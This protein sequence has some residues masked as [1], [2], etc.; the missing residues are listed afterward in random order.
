MKRKLPVF[1]VIMTVLAF[2]CFVL[3]YFFVAYCFIIPQY[4]KGLLFAIPFA[5][6][7]I[8]TICAYFGKVRKEAAAGITAVLSFVFI[9]SAFVLL[10]F[11]SFTE[12]TRAVED[13]AYYERA[14]TR[15]SV[16]NCTDG[17]ELLLPQNIPDN[18]EDV[19]FYYT[20]QVLQG[21]EIFFI[22]FKT[23]DRALDAYENELTQYA[24]WS[25][26]YEQAISADMNILYP[27]TLRGQFDY[28][29]L[30]DSY[31][32]YLLTASPEQTGQEHNHGMSYTVT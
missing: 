20:P 21:G 14:L 12:G 31:V 26:T 32:L 25:G 2:I 19:V 18:A 1:P 23:D 8:L 13:P 30:P 10:M 6:L 27:H 15:S 9:A 3:V 11:L 29:K 24:L 7:L 17:N 28:G 16:Q 4:A 5:V 22:S